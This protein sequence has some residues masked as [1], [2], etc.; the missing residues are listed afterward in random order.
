M[1]HSEIY[2]LNRSTNSFIEI[3]STPTY[4]PKGVE[5]TPDL[6]FWYTFLLKI[7]SIA[8]TLDFVSQEIGI[9]NLEAN[10]VI[11]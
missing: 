8:E 10:Q 6:F 4:W 2:Y 1:K 9:T 7:G 11:Q 3:I 5:K